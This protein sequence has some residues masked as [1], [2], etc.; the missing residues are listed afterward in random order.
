MSRFLTTAVAAAMAGALSVP[1]AAGATQHRSEAELTPRLAASA[2]SAPSALHPTEGRSATRIQV[3]LAEGSSS[4]LRTAALSGEGDSRVAALNR[5]GTLRD[6]RPMVDAPASSLRAL[7]A[8]AEQ[9]SGDEQADM[10]LWLVAE[11]APGEMADTLAQLNADPAVEVAMAA[12]LPV[13]PP[14]AGTSPATPLAALR[15]DATDPVNPLATPDFTDRQTYRGPA[16]EQGIEALA[17]HEMPGG[18]GKNVAVA[19]VEFGWTMDHEDLTQLAREDA[20]IA[21]G[22]PSYSYPEHG[23]SVMGEIIGDANEFGVTGIAPEATGYV[24]NAVS[25]EA[26]FTPGAAIAGAAEVLEPGDVILLEQ[27]LTGCGGGFA[28]VEIDPAAYDAIKT[29]V[30]KGIHVVEAAGNGAQ[31]LDDPCY[32]GEGF[33]DGKGDSGAI[34]VGAGASSRSGRTPGEVLSYST[35]GSRVNVQGWGEM[36]ASAGYGDLQGG[37]E[38]VQYTD[39]FSGTSSASPIVTGAVALV[40]S[41]AQEKG[42]ELDPAAMR[43]LLMETGTPQAGNDSAHIGPLPNVVKAVEGLGSGS[44]E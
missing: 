33:P 24:A 9:R 6:V 44:A 26:G 36:V 19:D 37:D 8:T 39:Q 43:T 10:S 40:S 3:K 29:A 28:P 41:I 30:A 12:P 14:R 13:Q 23:T 31:D 27:Q 32:G 34:I 11:V 20:L 4:A 42:V 38:T 7:K 21:N 16:D 35:Y 5:S 22:T 15:T 17:A 2:D 1:V 25:A 18:K